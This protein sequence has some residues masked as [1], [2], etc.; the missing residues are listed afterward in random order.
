MRYKLFFECLWRSNCHSKWEQLI[1][2]VGQND[3]LETF[4]DYYFIKSGRRM[5]RQESGDREGYNEEL[6]QEASA[7]QTR[8]H[9]DASGGLFDDKSY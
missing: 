1:G 5:D 9:Y 4:L 8:I 7:C 2:K 6:Q 3:G